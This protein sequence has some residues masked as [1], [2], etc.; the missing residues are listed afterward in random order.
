MDM[1]TSSRILA[2]LAL[3]PAVAA[4]MVTNDFQPPLGIPYHSDF[5]TPA[6]VPERW[7]ID[8]G[9]WAVSGGTFNSNGTALAVATINDYTFDPI[10]APQPTIGQYIFRARV[11][12]QGA[13]ASSLAGVVFDYVDAANYS[14]AE[15]NATGAYTVRQVVD[16]TATTLQTGTFNGGA[17]IWFDVEV[18][19]TE[20]TL[21]VLTNGVGP[22]PLDVGRGPRFGGR[23]GVTSRNAKASFDKV[24][25]AFRFG[26]QPF[27]DDF[28]NGKLSSWFVQEGTWAT[29]DGT[30]TSTSVQQNSVIGNTNP[31]ISLFAN[32]NTS[33]LMR[34]RMLNP[35]GA[36][37]NLVGLYAL[38]GPCCEDASPGR[39]EVLFS[40][41]GQARI[42]LTHNGIT[43][44]IASAP[45]PGRRN[46]WFD[47]RA[48]VFAGQ[49]TV[50]VNGTTIFDHVGTG[51]VLEGGGGLITHWSPGKFDDVW[52]DNRTTFSP[53][54]VPFDTAPPA[55]WIVS[56]TWNASGGTL[57]NVSAGISDVVTTACPC[58]E[59]DFVYRARLLNQYG[60][61]GNLVGL[62]YNYQRGVFTEGNSAAYP[63]IYSGDYY[64]VVFSPTGQAFINKVISGA[65]YRVAN[66]THNVPRNVWFDV[67]VARLGVSTTVKVNG[68]TVF[69]KIPQG[70]LPFGAVGVVSHWSKARFD[71]L[72][73]T[74]PIRQAGTASALPAGTAPFAR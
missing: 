34:A 18:I 27:K 28:T 7:Q 36:A 24:S 47:V 4:G 43:E 50:A 14:V 35:Y 26:G 9:V 46:Q 44:T 12:S 21:Q 69:D 6:A 73:V 68:V 72:T 22:A 15:Y 25:I 57:N 59:S 70:E 55:D 64:E 56:G 19:R 5:D 49:I 65:R 17:N 20:F 11:R 32:E 62:V 67:E 74:D 38:A 66:G 71:N 40:P 60:A 52:F 10:S 29:G 45:Y 53:L 41:L 23:L 8:S 33:Y 37:G 16:G 2:W 58:W 48:N 51:E 13:G 30:L 1:R 63:G 31:R 61:S 54:S 3:L 42:D 39:V